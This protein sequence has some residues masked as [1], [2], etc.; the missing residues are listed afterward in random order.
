MILQFNYWIDSLVYKD[1]NGN[2]FTFDPNNPALPE[3]EFEFIRFYLHFAKPKAEWLGMDIS[4]EETWDSSRY[5]F[6]YTAGSGPYLLGEFRD[7][8]IKPYYRRADHIIQV[9]DDVAK[10]ISDAINNRPVFYI[11]TEYSPLKDQNVQTEPKR[12]FPF[13]AARYDMIIRFEIEL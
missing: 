2:T 1:K 11:I 5:E 10:I 3:V 4:D 7:V 8:N 9:K 6:D 13:V 12:Y